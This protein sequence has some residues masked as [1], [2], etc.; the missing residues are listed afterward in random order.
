[1]DKVYLVEHKLHSIK[2]EFEQ[3]L[4]SE[5]SKRIQKDLLMFVEK[6]Y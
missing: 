1:M 3:N 2:V 6:R 4:V 5:F